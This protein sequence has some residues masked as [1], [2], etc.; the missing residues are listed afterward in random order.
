MGNNLSY[1]HGARCGSR[2]VPT[3]FF[4]PREFAEDETKSNKVFFS[5]IDTACL[6][7]GATSYS[8]DVFPCRC[9]FF[10]AG[11]TSYPIDAGFGWREPSETTADSATAHPGFVSFG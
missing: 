1:R 2:G 7:A 8:I 5:C 10:K 3:G 6:T 4:I 9:E 11:S